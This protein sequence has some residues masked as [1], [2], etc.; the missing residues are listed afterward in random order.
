MVLC[1]TSA[2]AAS[3][4]HALHRP[5]VPVADRDRGELQ[6]APA[7]RTAL[8]GD[9][10]DACLDAAADGSTAAPL[11]PSA[12][13]WVARKADPRVG[14]G[15]VP[16]AASAPA[17]PSMGGFRA[18]TSLMGWTDESEPVTING[19]LALM[20]LDRSS[21]SST[22]H[23]AKQCRD[24]M[25]LGGEPVEALSEVPSSHQMIPCAKRRWRTSRRTERSG[26]RSRAPP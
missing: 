8:V 25:P 17:P 6:R 9:L 15:E 22:L 4:R 2:G 7:G 1:T 18:S 5:R 13:P 19:G 20:R 23:S 14:C 12:N 24:P 11:Q 16:G 21:S 26:M 10:C 3:R